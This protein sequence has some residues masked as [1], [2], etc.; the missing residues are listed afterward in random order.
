M[1]SNPTPDSFLPLKHDVLLILLSL[2]DGALHGYGILR[3]L[4]ERSS[5]EIVLQTGALYRTLRRMLHDGLIEESAPPRNADGEDLRRCYYRSTRLGTAV[6]A[7]EVARM[8][9]LVRAAKL[10]DLG[11]RPRLA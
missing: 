8:Q 1:P 3:D 4:E 2:G 6:R 10:T 5:G 11:K 7:A 9:R